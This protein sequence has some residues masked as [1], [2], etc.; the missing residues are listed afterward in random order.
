MNRVKKRALAVGTGVLMLSGALAGCQDFLETP[1]QGALDEL[2]LANRQ[3]V[4]ATLIGA[5]RMLDWANFG[6]WGA[7]ASN[8]PFGS[9]PSDDA[10]KGSDP[11]DQNQITSLELYTWETGGAETY[12]NDRW[13]RLYEGVV[14][15]NSTIRLLNRVRA[16]RPGEISDALASSIRGEALFLRAQYHFEAWR[17]WGNI[18]YYR[19]DDLDVRKPN[20]PS[21]EA[22]AAILADLDEA[23]AL[24]PPT[25]R[26]GQVG[27]ATSWTARAYKGRTQVYAASL[28]IGGVTWG[29]A[30]ATLRQVRTEG[31]YGLEENFHRV[32]TGFV[33]FANGP[34]TILAFQASSNDGD[35]GGNNANYGERLNFP[36][37]GS[38]FGC[39]GFHQPSQ[40]LVNF[41]RV[42]ANGLPLALT[43]PNWNASDDNFAAGNMA[44][45]DPRLDWTV[46]R[47]G[48]PFKDWGP[49]ESSWIRDPANGGPYSPKKHVH[50]DA[51]GAESSAGWV[52]TQLNSVNQH[53]FRYGDLLLMLAEAE[54][55]AGSPESA[56][57]IV[58]E[59]RARAGVAAQGPGTSTANI[60]V[61]LDHP[62]IT[63]ANYRVGLYNT[64]WADQAF[65]RRA[66]RYERRLELA[67][68]AE[69]FFDLTRWGTAPEVLNEFIAVERRRRPYLAAAA[70]VSERHRLWPIPPTQITLSTL[71]DGTS[72]L[73]QNPGW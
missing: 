22:L 2:T 59:I 55:E 16:D 63:W 35:P 10:Y 67:M 48:V 50:E 9:V 37:A 12:L 46:G 44:P 18:P 8:W 14:R 60:A 49:H 71:P 17:T 19:E 29:D 11:A 26:N 6:G 4:E 43:D 54:V 64:P 73:Q 68:E 1:P 23:I 72:P 62:S 39:C 69:R 56:R 40:N 61:P 34:E 5:Y 36:H 31:P 28:N 33:Q 53:L 21:A 38:P 42:D 32:W 15:T 52:P 25:P 41:Y 65:A 7:A 57:Q 30:L 45:V 70:T 13:R 58:N 51:S 27:R 24:L 3:G 20:S 66:V 47:D